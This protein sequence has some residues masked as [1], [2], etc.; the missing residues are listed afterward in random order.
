MHISRAW[1]GDSSSPQGRLSEYFLREISAHTTKI[2]DV[3]P[4]TDSP[5]VLKQ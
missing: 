3:Y 1:G 5:V 4:V 2:K